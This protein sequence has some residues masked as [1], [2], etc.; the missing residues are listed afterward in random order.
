MSTTVEAIYEG[1][2]LRL[3]APMP[4]AD[5]TAVRVTVE[6]LPAPESPPTGEPSPRRKSPAEIMEEISACYE[7]HGE[8]GETSISEHH[9]EILYGWK[10]DRG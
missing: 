7:D 9:D 5:G 4:L 2:I 6:A 8:G 1:G 10:K 3:K